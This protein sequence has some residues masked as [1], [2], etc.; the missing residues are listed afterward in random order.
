LAGAP[1]DQSRTLPGTDLGKTKSFYVVTHAR[2][3]RD[4]ARLIH[5]QLVKRGDLNAAKKH[6][7]TV[8]LAVTGGQ[9][10]NPMWKTQVS[11]TSFAEA[12]SE[13]YH[14]LQSFLR[15]CPGQGWK[16]P[17]GCSAGQHDATVIRG[18]FHGEHGGGLVSARTDS[19]TAVWQASVKS[20]HT[21]KVSDALWEQNDYGWRLKERRRI[22][23]SRDLK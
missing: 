5:E 18:E 2:D 16:L 22:I 6:P 3:K 21:A 4:V 1:I 9:E 11:D 13:R 12:L 8:S 14:P 10:A 17:T 23:S 15:R 19:A 7:H 20:S